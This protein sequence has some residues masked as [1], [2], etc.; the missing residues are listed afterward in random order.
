MSA[1][2]GRQN[3]KERGLSVEQ[4]KILPKLTAEQ[5]KIMTTEEKRAYNAKRLKEYRNAYNDLYASQVL[6][7]EIR[8]LKAEREIAYKFYK[9]YMAN[10]VATSV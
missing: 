7:Y 3:Q 4:S 6:G 9:E 8:S 2:N 10:Q 1:T 5:R